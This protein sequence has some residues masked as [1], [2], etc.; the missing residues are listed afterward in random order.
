MHVQNVSGMH[1]NQ[2]RVQSCGHHM[3]TDTYRELR[4]ENKNQT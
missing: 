3:H 4:Q 1:R 2:Q